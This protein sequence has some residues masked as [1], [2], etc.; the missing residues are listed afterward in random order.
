MNVDYVSRLDPSSRITKQG[1]LPGQGHYSQLGSWLKNG[2]ALGLQSGEFNLIIEMMSGA[3]IDFCLPVL[4]CP[5]SLPS[6]VTG[7]I[8]LVTVPLIPEYL[9]LCEIRDQEEG[10]VLTVFLFQ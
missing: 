10:A 1:H 8:S 2:G 9:P 3:A 5:L 7:V 6:H 4:P